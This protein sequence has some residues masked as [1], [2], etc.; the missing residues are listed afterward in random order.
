MD[1]INEKTNF[2]ELINK[3]TGVIITKE[4]KEFVLL[5][6]LIRL[7]GLRGI[8]SNHTHIAQAPNDHNGSVAVATVTVEFKDGRISAGSAD[9]SPDNAGEG[10]FGLYPTAIAESRALARALRLGMGIT[11]CSYEEVSSAERNG[12]DKNAPINGSAKTCIQELCK[13]KGLTVK[14]ALSK[15]SRKV[16]SLDELTQEEGTSLIGFLNKQPDKKGKKG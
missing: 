8:K 13:R 7:A 1:E 4:G 6:E 15:G 14:D 16:D 3:E 2:N 10:S 5:A 9:C 12:F 11:M